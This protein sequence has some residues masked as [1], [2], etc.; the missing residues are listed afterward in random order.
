MPLVFKSLEIEREIS[1]R[2]GDKIAISAITVLGT[3]L[4][5]AIA[6]GDELK[7]IQQEFTTLPHFSNGSGTFWFGDDAKFIFLNWNELMAL[8]DERI[9]NNEG[10]FRIDDTYPGD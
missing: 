7:L 10:I 4:L 8:V 1:Y 3:D 6:T 2:I 5:V 9:Q